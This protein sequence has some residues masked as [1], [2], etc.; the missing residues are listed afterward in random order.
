MNGASRQRKSELSAQNWKGDLVW[1]GVLA[2]VMREGPHGERPQ[3]LRMG[4]ES[5]AQC[6]RDRSGLGNTGKTA[7]W[8]CRQRLGGP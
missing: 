3:G 8:G 6:P 5:S 1:R 2:D 4:P 7:R